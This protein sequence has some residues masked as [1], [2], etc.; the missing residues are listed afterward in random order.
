MGNLITKTKNKIMSSD[1]YQKAI[2]A[3]CTLSLAL[4]RTA[5]ADSV[6]I[7]GGITKMVSYVSMV[8]SGVGIIYAIVAIFN[9]VSAIKQEEPER[10]S[11]AIVNV[12]VAALL[13]LIGPITSIIIKAFGVSN[14]YGL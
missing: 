8:V 11:K 10:A 5:M 7:N 1:L 13:I 4:P 9:W 3:A 2:V 6:N 14:T 12:F